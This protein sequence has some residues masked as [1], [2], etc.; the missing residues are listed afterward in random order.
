[1]TGERDKRIGHNE[2]LYRQV[3]ER[4]E[5]LS[6]AFSMRTG[7]FAIVCECGE[8]ECMEQVV[9]SREVYE[10]T[11][12]NPNRFIVKPG[13]ELKDIERIVKRYGGDTYVVVEKE[14]PA[15]RQVAEETD[16]RA[17]G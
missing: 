7:D 17:D 16:P 3:N 2:A 10:Q 8:L 6:E 9:V 11:R 4:I 12:E 1:V 15:A 14:A 13:H 5:D